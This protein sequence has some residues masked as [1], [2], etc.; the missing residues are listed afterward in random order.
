MC[1]GGGEGYLRGRGVCIEY[2][3]INVE[4]VM[5]KYVALCTTL[6][7]VSQCVSVCPH[8]E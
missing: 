8:G 2:L 7:C 5:L 3:N 4:Y 1:V 6:F